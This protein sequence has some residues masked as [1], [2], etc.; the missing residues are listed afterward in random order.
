[1]ITYDFT[2]Q[3][4]VVTGSARGI[5]RRC[6]ERFLEA[7][8]NV[9]LCG[10][11]P[12]DEA[13]LAAELDRFTQGHAERVMYAQC[14]VGDATA[15]RRFLDAASERFGGVHVLVNNAGI[16]QPSPV[17]TL[18]E[19]QWR[20][21]T[22]INLKSQAFACDW[23]AQR[24]AEGGPGRSIVNI[25]SVS[26]S[27]TGPHTVL[28]NLEKAGVNSLTRTYAHGLGAFGVNVNAVAPG[29][30]A[31]DLNKAAYADPEAERA[32]CESLVMGRRGRVDDIA[33]AVLFLASE[34]SAYITGQVLY[35]DGGWLL[36][37]AP[38]K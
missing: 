16:W 21:D 10:Q 4:V 23:F 32:M 38:R 27:L 25:S 14:D 34:E 31:T 1:M 26:S 5:G 19:A 22:D 36:Q 11:S 30:V 9:A 7:G 15:L 33:N 37:Q 12:R 18:T 8:A 20:R 29:S 17:G 13:Q 24:C 3:T 2:N 28:Y 35:V 6:A